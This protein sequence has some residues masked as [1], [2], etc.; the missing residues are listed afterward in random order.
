SYVVADTRVDGGAF[1]EFPS[2][3]GRLVAWGSDSTSLVFDRTRMRQVQLANPPGV[4]GFAGSV[5]SH[6]LVSEAPLTQ[7]DNQ[8]SIKGQPFHHVLRV[9]DSNTL[10]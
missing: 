3:N 10:P 8:A 4:G 7:A 2:L 5:C 9:L 1:N 6:F